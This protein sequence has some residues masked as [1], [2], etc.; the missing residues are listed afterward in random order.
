MALGA[1]LEWPVTRAGLGAFVRH[2]P[3]VLRI[4]ELL[5]ALVCSI[6]AGTSIPAR[7]P[8]WCWR[9]VPWHRSRLG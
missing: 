7:G 8:S 3:V 1:L 4:L 5:L 6:T 2:T 9:G